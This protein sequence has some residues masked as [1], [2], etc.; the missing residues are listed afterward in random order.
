MKKNSKNDVE[1]VL[2]LFD[3]HK[4]TIIESIHINS[5]G[6]QLF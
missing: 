2:V 3:T 6:L 4:N 5:S 1:I